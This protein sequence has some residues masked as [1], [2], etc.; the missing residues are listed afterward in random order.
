VDDEDDSNSDSDS[1][2]NGNSKA[3]PKLDNGVTTP[4]SEDSDV[5]DRSIYNALK[6]KFTAKYKAYSS[7]RVI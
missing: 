2:S 3:A 6:V 7:D 1:N 4:K 5:N